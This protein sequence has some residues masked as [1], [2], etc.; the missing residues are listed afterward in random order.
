MGHQVLIVLVVAAEV[1][2]KL[3]GTLHSHVA[4]GDES[5]PLGCQRGFPVMI[6]GTAAADDSEPEITIIHWH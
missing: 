3:L 6:G 2:W 4:A 5:N 1:V